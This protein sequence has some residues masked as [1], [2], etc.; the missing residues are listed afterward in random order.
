[1]L[2][3]NYFSADLVLGYV[4]GLGCFLF[5][6]WR[7]TQVKLL[8]PVDWTILVMGMMYGFGLPLVIGQS[9]MVIS[10]ANQDLLLPFEGRYMIHTFAAMIATAG[11]VLG[12]EFT[13]KRRTNIGHGLFSGVVSIGSYERAFWAMLLGSALATYLYVYDYGGI[14]E[15]LQYSRQIRSGVLDEADLSRFSFVSPFRGLSELAFLGFLGVLLSGKRDAGVAFG[16]ALSFLLSLY[17]LS[18]NSGRMGFVLLLCTSVL[19]IT[20]T[21]RL[22]PTFMVVAFVF[23]LPLLLFS[24]YAGSNF[25]GV[26]G[27]TDFSNF[28][29]RELSFL[30]TSFFGQLHVGEHHW[31]M[32]YD[33]LIAPI[34]FLPSR[35]YADWLI[36]VEDVNTIVH[37][38]F[39]KGEGGNTANV[40]VDMVTFGLMQM[41][42]LGVFLFAVLFGVISSALHGLVQSF[43]FAGLYHVFFAYVCIYFSSFAVFY[44]YPEHII[45]SHFPAIFSVLVF[46]AWRFFNRSSQRPTPGMISY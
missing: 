9:R 38:G 4:Y 21:K 12:W 29:S 5:V 28:A 23:I 22:K 13:E 37:Y 14:I 31:R 17:G 30:F 15:A 34:Y 32:F 42:Y 33:V 27:D 35:F 3:S 20:F 7:S 36:G 40:P 16:L 6:L 39:R 11:V 41:H 46:I 19:A 43:R 24:V 2:L 44:A 45:G 8:R 26:K 10:F 1:M 18:L 25:F